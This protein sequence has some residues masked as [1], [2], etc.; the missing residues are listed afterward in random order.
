MRR[1]GPS[2]GHPASLRGWGR[3]SGETPR[4][5]VAPPERNGS[6]RA[7][8]VAEGPRSYILPGTGSGERKEVS[9][10]PRSRPPRLS[11]PRRATE[12]PGE[13]APVTSE[14]PE[15]LSTGATGLV[16]NHGA[17]SLPKFYPQPQHSDPAAPL[18]PEPV[19][20]NGPARPRGFLL[21]LGQQPHRIPL[22]PRV[23]VLV[24]PSGVPVP[25]HPTF[26]QQAT[27]P[28]SFPD[29]STPGQG[30]G[31]EEE[32]PDVWDPVHP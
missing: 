13:T 16:H 6:L 1:E 8:L 25:V 21:R 29:L 2:L 32:A 20:V 27:P 15:A 28:L 12:P 11:S 9:P 31:R 10:Y 3:D 19:D 23:R 14:P 24:G 17:P 26:L 18:Y 5:S 4:T 7:P 30:R 22:L